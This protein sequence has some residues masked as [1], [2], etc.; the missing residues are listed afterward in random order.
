MSKKGV[1][2]TKTI[3]FCAI[4]TA[5]GVIVARFLSI[6]PN[7]ST[8]FSFES[9]P[10][11]LSGVLFGPLAGAMV[12]FATDFIGCLFSPYGFNPLM[13]LPPVLYGLC[14]G[15]FQ[16]LIMK[17][18]SL[19]RIFAAYFPAVILG[20]ILWQSYALSTVSGKGF[21]F[22]LGTR[23]IQFAVV[24]VLD[25]LLTWMLFKSRVF[26]AAGLW[27]PIGRKKEGHA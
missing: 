18:L 13:C 20:S 24:F 25:A 12:G 6:A 15:L 21:L 2:T 26:Q 9:V 10:I 8:R 17:K 27:P 19:F 16:G 5:L 11:F 1:I 22:F 7:E 3:A 23:S 14:G 4:F